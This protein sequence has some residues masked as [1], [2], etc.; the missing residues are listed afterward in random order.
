MS[1]KPISFTTK[2]IFSEKEG[3]QYPIYVAG[4]ADNCIFTN[5]TFFQRTA[6]DSYELYYDRDKKSVNLRSRDSNEPTP[7]KGEKPGQDSDKKN[8]KNSSSYAGSSQAKNSTALL[9]YEKVS[10]DVLDLNCKMI[11][12]YI[13]NIHLDENYR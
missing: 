11:K 6:T 5:Y 2:L 3:K 8:D 7:R 10:N 1:Q 4:T 9:G 12:K 13:K